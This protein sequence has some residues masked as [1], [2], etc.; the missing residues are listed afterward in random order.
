MKSASNVLPEEPPNGVTAGL[1]WARDD[2]AV[3]VVDTRGRELAR[4]SIAHSAAGLRTWSRN[5]PG[6]AA[7]RSRSNAATARSSMRCWPPV[8]PWW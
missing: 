3:S 5:S 6:P 8:S 1:D 2:H 7:P 4:H